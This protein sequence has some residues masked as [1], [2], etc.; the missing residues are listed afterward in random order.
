MQQDVA[1]TGFPLDECK[2]ERG[3]MNQKD[4]HVP[5]KA[6]PIGERPYERFEV[7]GASAL[8][9]A[10]LLA[11][12]LR[13]GTRNETSVVLAQN[14]LSHAH[15]EKNILGL[16]HMSIEELMQIP[17]IGKVKAIQLK[18]IAELSI[19]FARTN[20]RSTLFM[21]SPGT[22]AHYYM[23]SCRHL[24]KEQA[25]VILLNG[26]NKLITDFTLSI[27]TA[28]RT[29]VSTREVFREAL[30]YGAVFFMLLHNHPGG[31]PTPSTQDIQLTQRMQEAGEIMDL[32]LIDHIII[33][34]NKYISM[35]ELGLF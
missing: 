2:S 26:S 20:A 15:S 10:E 6:L 17:G 21:D 13:T 9:D 19:R 30:K 35:R 11:I 31:D 12:I 7:A 25:L 1:S 5:L 22:V 34:D 27:G 32:E 4:V 29:L 28:N 33:G 23:E 3:N 24:E 18:S 14:V 16:H 8:S